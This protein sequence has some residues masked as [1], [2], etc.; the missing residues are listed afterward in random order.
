MTAAECD[1]LAELE[2]TIAR[3]L[4]RVVEVGRSLREIRD[5]GLYRDVAPSFEL[6]MK[7]RWDFERRSAYNY[8]DVADVHD[9][10]VQ[11]AAHA[12]PLPSQRVAL[13]LVPVMRHANGSERVAEVWTAVGDQHEGDRPPTP[14]EVRRVIAASGYRPNSG[15][16]SGPVNLRVALGDF[17]DRLNHATQRLDLFEKRDR[18]GR[19]LHPEVQ[20]LA[21]EYA[22]RCDALAAR[23][24]QLGEA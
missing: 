10:L 14:A 24:R 6:Y 19:D 16:G 11:H 2:A 23:L 22:D 9:A 20:K 7:Q 21:L 1:R 13:E 4:E 5:R 15:S 17:G 3:D 18:K 8:I 12:V